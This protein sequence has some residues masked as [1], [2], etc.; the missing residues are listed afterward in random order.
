MI[1]KINKY[2][3]KKIVIGVSSGV[4]SMVLFDLLKGHDI[5]VAHINHN[6]RPES[7]YEQTYLKDYCLSRS[8]PF[9]TITLEYSSSELEENFQL[10]ARNKRYE[11]YKEVI[12][13]YNADLL[14][15][16]H[17]GDDLV[18][19]VLMSMVRGTSLRGLIGFSAESEVNNLSII[20]PLIIYS[21][22]D[23]LEYA[24]VN[25]LMYFEDSSNKSDKYTRNRYRNTILPFLKNETKNIHNKF[26]CLSEDLADV[27]EF[28]MISV[29]KFIDSS[30]RISNFQILH[31]A[32]QREVIATLLKRQSIT[33]NSNLINE[34]V[35]ILIHNEPNAVIHLPNNLVVLR[36][37]DKFTI[38]VDQK[39][40]DYEIEI[41]ELGTYNLPNGDEIFVGEKK[42]KIHTSSYK[43]C[44]NNTVFPIVIRNRRDGD[45]IKLSFGTKKIKSLFIDLKIPLKKR[46]NQPLVIFEDKIVWIPGIKEGLHEETNNY[47]YINYKKG[48]YHG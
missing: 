45:K 30:R 26:L 4:D 16:A 23:I 18:E 14:A 41:N 13:K 42:S 38:Q 34:I 46:N 8:I 28:I 37:Y 36:E 9:E 5:V 48:D 43:L 22:E 47:V 1:Q 31:K 21:K 32:V 44:Y 27:Y 11:F 25:E 7:D 24:E 20:R 40:N 39:F 19:T 12:E 10:I 29:N 15:L 6:M 2:F 33:F 3:N 35:S 17:H